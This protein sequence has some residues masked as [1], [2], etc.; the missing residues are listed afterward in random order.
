MYDTETKGG[1]SKYFEIFA[2]RYYLQEV[3]EGSEVC[4][5]AVSELGKQEA[6]PGWLHEL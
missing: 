6:G 2:S 5:V 3:L 1:A 4:R